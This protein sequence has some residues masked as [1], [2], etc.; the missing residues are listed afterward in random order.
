[1]IPAKEGK[2][3]WKDVAS[4]LAKSLQ[5]DAATLEGI[6]PNGSLD[7]HSRATAFA[8]RGMDI[9]LGDAVSFAIVRDSE[10]ETALRVTCDRDAIR[11]LAATKRETKTARIELDD[12][13]KQRAADRPLV[14]CLHGLRSDPKRFEAFRA[15]LRGSGLATAAASYDDHQSMKKSARQLSELAKRMFRAPNSPDLVLVG[16]SMGGLVAREWTENRALNNRRIVSL[17]T[18]GTPHGGS[19][20]ASMPPLLDLVGDEEFHVRDVVD[21]LLH[22]PSAPGMRELV[23]DSDFLNELNSRDRR[24]DVRYTT[25]AGTRSPVSE[26]QVTR[27]RDALLQARDVSTTVRLLQPRIDPLL[28][29]FDELVQG[30]GDGAVAVERAKIEGVNDVVTVDVSHGDFFG[31]ASAEKERL[32]WEAIG[33][34][35]DGR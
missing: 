32:V 13:W 6:F 18:A 21:V 7:L 28:S 33:Q 11:L 35:V 25:I 2:I 12:D 5:L 27:I 4:S 26:Q 14:I 16:H 9:A 20:W 31:P 23:P 19:S 29:S 30:K 1:M 10:G 34:R 15:Y 8:L 24:R 22:Q 3:V 17:V